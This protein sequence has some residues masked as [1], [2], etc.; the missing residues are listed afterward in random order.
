[1][2]Q[3]FGGKVPVTIEY[4]LDVSQFVAALEAVAEQCG[5]AAEALRQFA[6]ATDP[7][8]VAEE[9]LDEVLGVKGGE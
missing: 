4:K 6:A 5:K 1:M 3:A 9:I 7:D 2:A 8:D